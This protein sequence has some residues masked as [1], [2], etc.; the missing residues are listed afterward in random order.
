VGMLAERW[1]PGPPWSSLANA[2]GS[3]CWSSRSRRTAT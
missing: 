2:L 3:C 1:M